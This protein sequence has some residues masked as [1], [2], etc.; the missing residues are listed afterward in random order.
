MG[1]TTEELGHR[2]AERVATADPASIGDPAKSL[3]NALA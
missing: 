1:A 2:I 3:I